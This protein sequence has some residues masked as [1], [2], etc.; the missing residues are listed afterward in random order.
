LI[1]SATDFVS[2][3]A[4]AAGAGSASAL[5]GQVDD[6]DGS[7]SGEETGEE[8]MGEEEKMLAR[9]PAFDPEKERAMRAK[10]KVVAKREGDGKA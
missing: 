7:D 9:A 8:G 5:Q 1:T 6:I 3:G 10:N 4:A 2:E